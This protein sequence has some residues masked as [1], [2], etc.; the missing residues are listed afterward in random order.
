MLK[1][2]ARHLSLTLT[3]DASSVFTLAE[4]FWV[5]SSHETQT[6][7]SLNRKGEPCCLLLPPPALVQQT[8]PCSTHSHYDLDPVGTKPEFIGRKQERQRVTQA[9]SPALGKPPAAEAE[10][11]S[12][13]WKL[14]PGQH[15]PLPKC[16]QL[17]KKAPPSPACP[18][19]KRTGSML[20]WN[21]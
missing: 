12:C 8:A 20:V 5:S 2:P 14:L 4:E 10:S 17:L 15:K 16:L 21:N 7:S 6:S 13:W 19:D 9:A 18:V 3:E 1:L 11:W